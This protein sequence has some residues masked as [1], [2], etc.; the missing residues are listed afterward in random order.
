MRWSPNKSARAKGAKPVLI[1]LHSTEGNFDGAVN[2]LMQSRARASAHYVIGINGEFKKLVPLSAKAWH[3]R[4]SIKFGGYDVNSVSIG[5][6]LENYAHESSKKE[7][8]TKYSV[9]QMDRLLWLMEKLTRAYPIRGIAAHC[10]L[11]PTRRTDP[12]DFPWRRFWRL[13]AK[14]NK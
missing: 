12:V 5:I 8:R 4:G 6:E 1:V 3:V 13:L 11:D 14:G 9:A 2:W 7:K 10:D